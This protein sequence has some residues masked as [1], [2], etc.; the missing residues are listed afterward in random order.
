ML[1]L[2]KAESGAGVGGKG[3]APIPT[4][5]HIDAADMAV[6]M[7]QMLPDYKLLP[8]YYLTLK[9]EHDELKKQFNDLVNILK[10]K[11]GMYE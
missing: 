5:L 2:I 10:E 7:Q 9:M 3:D 4:P 6:K 1:N 11:G 8:L